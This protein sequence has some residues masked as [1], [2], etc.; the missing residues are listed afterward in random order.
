MPGIG[1]GIAVRMSP[2]LR[3]AAALVSVAASLL[4][5]LGPSIPV[6]AQ[7]AGTPGERITAGAPV[8][9]SLGELMRIQAARPA[10]TRPY[11]KPEFE[12]DRQGLPQSPS[13]I[14]AASW[15]PGPDIS[16]GGSGPKIAPQGLGTNWDGV[17]GPTETGAFPPDTMGAPGPTQFVIF[18]NGRLR[19]FSKA[20]G[21]A[22]GVLNVN[23]D[24][25]FASVVTPPGS[26]EVSFASCASFGQS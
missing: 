9:H 12:V 14:S 22:D 4:F 8:R 2:R 5:V 7:R 3:S 15:P 20:T 17:T 19:S 18:V 10:S 6:F 13:A 1:G 24:V 11:R 25:F 21:T 16:R 26:G 23:P